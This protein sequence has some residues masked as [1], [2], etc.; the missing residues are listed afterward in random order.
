MS[1]GNFRAPDQILLRTELHRRPGLGDAQPV[2]SAELRPVN[3]L[4]GRAGGEKWN[5]EYASHAREL[6]ISRRDPSRTWDQVYYPNGLTRNLRKETYGSS[7]DCVVDWG[8]ERLDR[9]IDHEG[10]GFGVVGNIILGIVGGIVG[11]WLLGR[12]GLS[13][14]TTSGYLNAIVTSVIGSVVILFVAGLLKK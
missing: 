4:C 1:R 8:R 5:C 12:L 7:V 14:G 6:F 3:R 13:V 9:R 10:G 11:G 2:R